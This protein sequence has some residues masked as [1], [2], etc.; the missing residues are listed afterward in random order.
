[1]RRTTSAWIAGTLGAGLTA[2]IVLA[3]QLPG[4]GA[5]AAGRFRRVGRVGVGARVDLRGLRLRA[6]RGTC[7]ATGWT[8][9]STSNTSGPQVPAR[10]RGQA[11]GAQRQRGCRTQAGDRARPGRPARGGGRD[12][13]LC[14][15]RPVAAAATDSPRPGRRHGPPSPPGPARRTRRS[16]RGAS[17]SFRS[18]GQRL[19]R[20]CGRE[21]EHGPRPDRR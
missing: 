11:E 10:R 2:S 6:G 3:Q 8:T 5:G 7:C 4:S 12:R 17:R 19:G 20:R 14:A 21:R 15:E 1:M 9:S 13:P 16:A 18:R